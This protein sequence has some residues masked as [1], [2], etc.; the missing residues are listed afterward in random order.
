MVS[1]MRCSTPE[2]ASRAAAPGTSVAGAQISGSALRAHRA[3]THYMVLALQKPHTIMS[4]AK[5]AKMQ[6][7]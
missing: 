1:L 2:S 5:E 3:S 6:N 4:I 7:D